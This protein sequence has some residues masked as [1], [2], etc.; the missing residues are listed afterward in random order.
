MDVFHPYPRLPLTSVRPHG[1]T[2]A[3]QVGPYGKAG[4]ATPESLSAFRSSAVYQ[5]RE[6]PCDDEA[7]CPRTAPAGWIRCRASC[8]C[9]AAPDALPGRRGPSAHLGHTP[10]M[11][12]PLSLLPSLRRLEIR[13]LADLEREPPSQDNSLR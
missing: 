9:S 4:A 12:R 10:P 1:S 2:S 7:A 5:Y 13:F 3:W 8:P 11:A 6:C